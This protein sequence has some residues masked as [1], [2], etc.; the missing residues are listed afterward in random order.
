[1]LLKVGFLSHILS[2]A[3]T[4]YIGGPPRSFITT[5]V[6]VVVVVAV[7]YCI[8]Y[9]CYDPKNL[10]ISDLFSL[11]QIWIRLC[12]IFEDFDHLLD[13]IL[14]TRSRSAIRELLMSLVRFANQFRLIFSVV[15]SLLPFVCLKTLSFISIDT[16]LLYKRIITKRYSHS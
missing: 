6:V 5:I 9:E 13:E 8:L 14:L 7:S 2:D 12:L 16:L 1:M 15:K 11:W 4:N 3:S 10:N